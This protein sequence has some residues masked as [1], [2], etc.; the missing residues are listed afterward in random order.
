MSKVKII[1]AIIVSVAVLAGAGAG[2]YFFFFADNDTPSSHDGDEKD[3]KDEKDENEEK[4]E[5]TTQPQIVMPSKEELVTDADVLVLP[6]YDSFF[7]YHIPQINYPSDEVQRFNEK[8]SDTLIKLSEKQ[9]QAV[10]DNNIMTY[11]NVYYTYGVRDNVVSILIKKIGAEYFMVDME[12]F[13]FD[14]EKGKELSHA[15]ALEFMGVTR[16]EFDESVK[17]A[18]ELNAQNTIPESEAGY[19]EEPLEMILSDEHISLALPFIDTDGNL[20]AVAR[21][22]S[23]GGPTY[24]NELI[25][26]ETGD[27]REITYC[28]EMHF[29][30]IY[31]K[32][33]DNQREAAVLYSEYLYEKG[34]KEIS[35]CEN[36]VGY[37]YDI[38]SCFADFLGD[39]TPEL[40][41]S[42]EKKENNYNNSGVFSADAL[43]TIVEGKVQL[44]KKAENWGGSGGGSEMSVR[45][46]TVNNCPCV[47]FRDF[48]RAGYVQ[49]MV[50]SVAYSVNYYPDAQSDTANSYFIYIEDSTKG[51]I[52][53]IKAETDKW[54]ENTETKEFR[55]YT[56]NGEYVTEGEYNEF[57][58]SFTSEDIPS[59]YEMK[60]VSSTAPCI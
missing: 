33:P 19:F 50:S 37:F 35:G 4:D 52:D 43:L 26:L 54:T 59:G 45:Y 56:I 41:I 14:I 42:Y 57:I 16:A 32:L 28:E 60:T 3:E 10:K 17:K 2:A 47:Y 49:N 22:I 1:I 24:F 46:D 30:V 55:Y 38:T 8:I 48:A 23:R 13:F 6:Y 21:V 25:S 18:V 36:S 5:E 44:V 29:D 40:L 53:T 27:A 39:S 15:E 7:C 34:H 9:L 11:G 51:D 20:L 31:E 58:D 12:V